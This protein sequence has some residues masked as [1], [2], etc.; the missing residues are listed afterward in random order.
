MDTR[1][2]A[3]SAD[4]RLMEWAELVAEC[5]RSEIS[6]K[7][8]CR[9]HGISER[10]YYYWQKRIFDRAILQRE[11]TAAS[12]S[13]NDHASHFVELPAPQ[14][15]PCM[16]Q[17]SE[18]PAASIRIGKASVNL[19]AGADPQLVQALCQVLKSC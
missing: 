5:R 13:V 9:Q 3:V 16:Q 4:Q 10:R 12:V 19:C 11:A 7:E 8:W 15:Q 2:A 14:E 17:I 6:C 18:T 1:L